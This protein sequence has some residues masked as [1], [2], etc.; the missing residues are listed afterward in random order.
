MT[1]LLQGLDVVIFGVLKYHL[2]KKRDEL[3]RTEG[4]VIDKRNFLEVLEEPW[5]KTFTKELIQKAFRKTGVV[6]FDP[7]VIKPEQLATSKETS[8]NLELPVLISALEDPENPV[9]ILANML[10]QM[11]IG[12]PSQP[13]ASSC[14]R[15]DHSN[16]MQPQP[17]QPGRSATCP[18]LAPEL[19]I[20]H[21][22]PSPVPT[23]SSHSENEPSPPPDHSHRLH[24]FSNALDNLAKSSVAHLIDPNAPVLSS[25][26]APPIY[27][28][29]MPPTSIERTLAQ[30]L[31]TMTPSTDNELMLMSMLRQREEYIKALELQ[32][33]KFQA[34]TVLNAAYATQLNTKLA[35]KEDKGK[36]KQGDQEFTIDGNARVVTD[37]EFVAACAK[38]KEQ[39]EEAEA[40]KQDRNEAKA[41]WAEA[42]KVWEVADK[43]R[44]T[45]AK[46]ARDFNNKI[47]ADHKK[48]VAKAKKEGKTVSAADMPPLR[49]VPKAVKKPLLKDFLGCCGA[50]D[51]SGDDAGGLNGSNADSSEQ[52]V[53]DDDSDDN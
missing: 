53:A 12:E 2:S 50:G 44:K 32:N 9:N 48:R 26:P 15:D 27:T 47:R 36:K 39:R 5:K 40:A 11:K 30:D 43:Q 20:T 38:L 4:K 14:S 31:L 28:Y 42:V 35:Y 33:V 45:D 18:A 46:D 51:G 21:S 10:V 41:R 7:S 23:R 37:P 22:P 29:T 1:H 13:L 3:W 16:T 52:D 19:R 17:D 8:G 25:D 49:K 6:P 34:A 24:T